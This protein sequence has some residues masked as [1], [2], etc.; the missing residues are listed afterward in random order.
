MT[1][2][3]RF[4]AKVDKSG[5][6]DACWPWTASISRGYGSIKASRPRRSILA[7][8]LSWELAHGPVSAGMFVCHHCDNPPCCNPAHLFLGTA[9]DNNADAV[10]KGRHPTGEEHP[11]RRNPAY[12]F[13]SRM[14]KDNTS[15]IRGVCWNRNRRKWCA[16]IQVGKKSIYLG[17]FDDLDAARRA[18]DVAH[19]QAT[20]R[21]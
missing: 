17:L 9:A 7:H 21:Q 3:E 10:S 20:V 1:L 18:Y 14:R 15:G 6:P 4:W 5:G 16:K 11:A 13:T 19:S 8:R 12:L 2:E